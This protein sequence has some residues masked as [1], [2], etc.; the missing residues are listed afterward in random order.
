M[1]VVVGYC[2]NNNNV[3]AQCGVGSSEGLPVYFTEKGGRVG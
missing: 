2:F 1:L 3:V